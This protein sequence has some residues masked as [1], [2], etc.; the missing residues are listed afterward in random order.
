MGYHARH[1]VEFVDQ[2][3]KP[4]NILQADIMYFLSLKIQKPPL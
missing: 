2:N 4:R 3:K 1:V